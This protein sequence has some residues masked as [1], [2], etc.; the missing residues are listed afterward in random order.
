MSIVTP[1]IGSRY[2]LHLRHQQ[3][4]AGSGIQFCL[5]VNALVLKLPR[6]RLL[7]KKYI[8]NFHLHLTVKLGILQRIQQSEAL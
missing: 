2:Y 8:Q 7:Q 1:V 4:D 5:D 6:T 3:I